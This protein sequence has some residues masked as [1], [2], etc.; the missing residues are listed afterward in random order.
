MK[1]SI[2]I[3]MISIA[4]ILLAIQCG[5]VPEI[6]GKAKY[7]HSKENLPTLENIEKWQDIWVK[8]SWISA[9][10]TS[11]LSKSEDLDAFKSR[12]I[13]GLRIQLSDALS[14]DHWLQL[15][16]SL[17]NELQMEMVLPKYRL[18]SGSQDLTPLNF[19]I[20]TFPDIAIPDGWDSHVRQFFPEWLDKWNLQKGKFKSVFLQQ[21]AIEST[22]Q[23]LFSEPNLRSTLFQTTDSALPKEMLNQVPIVKHLKRIRADVAY[24]YTKENLNMEPAQVTVAVLDTGVD[25]LHPDLKNQMFV[26][27]GEPVD[28]QDNDGNGYY[29]DVH[30]ID[31]T[32]PPHT[33]NTGAQPAPGAADLG[34]PGKSCPPNVKGDDQTQACG[35]GTHVAGIIAA[36]HNG[37]SLSSMGVCPS[38]RILSLRVSDRCLKPD[39][40]GDGGCT[41][42]KEPLSGD[43]Y[44][45]DGG[46][47]DSSQ[48][49]ALSYISQLSRKQNSDDLY[50]N[51]V[52]M[53][54][55]KYFRSRS[56]AY[57]IQNLLSHNV[58]VVAAAGNDNTD[59]P[60]YPAA[61]SSVVSVCATGTSDHRG[62]FGKS[63]FSNFGDWVDI[64]APGVDIASTVPGGTESSSPELKSGTSQA[65][66][67]VAGVIGYLMAVS[68]GT[69]SA[70]Q[71]VAEI[72]NSSNSNAL[73]NAPTNAGIYRVCYSGDRIC[74][75]LLGSGIIDMGAAIQRP[76]PRQSV[77]GDAPAR[78]VKAGCVVA[79]VGVTPMK[80]FW[81]FTTSVPFLLGQFLIMVKLTKKW[82]KKSK[83]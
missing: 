30:G 22:D 25:Y 47:S 19:S 11:E 3:L 69:K 41:L 68:R 55:G 50:T 74:D 60:S 33:R 10:R 38:C 14:M 78:P 46:I 79:Q 4:G 29:D 61:Y 26:N 1:I 40:S 36:Q 63:V 77:V 31:A 12:L 23:T 20:V 24:E 64:C 42:P 80:S 5:R 71:I 37:G 67:F 56:M 82:T 54:L 58:V 35:H 8:N 27:P 49:R 51:V 65:T 75:F 76:V 66:P 15:E 39:A 17:Q 18:N 83:K 81:L 16:N 45:V 52:N 44:E 59:I 73:Y 43:Q 28:G 70:S 9:S 34:G 13:S 2:K 6:R 53:S 72:K 62:E 57:L 21:K 48:V 7:E 32:F